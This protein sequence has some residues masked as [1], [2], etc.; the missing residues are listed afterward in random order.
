MF[1]LDN[2]QYK[3]ILKVDNLHIPAEKIT[4]ITGESGGGKTTLLR[5]LNHMISPT[6]GK[7]FYEGKDIMTADPIEH[8][9]KV[10]ML[11]QVPVIFPGSIERNL[12]IGRYFAAKEPLPLEELA[13]ILIR[14]KLFKELSRPAEELSGG[15]K[16]RLSL[17]RVLI[18]AAE[19]LLLDEPS[20]ALDEETEKLI[21][22][23]L[24]LYS[25]EN[26]KTLVMVTHAKE[27][28]VAHADF[29]V[30]ISEGEVKEGI[31]M[32]STYVEKSSV[33]CHNHK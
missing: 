5:L 12:N 17:A 21:M 1:Q 27:M 23:E 22:E 20:A 2:V 29:R 18:M 33:C 16:Q 9:R 13:E 7:V 28:A 4:C 19:T 26:K 8:R 3:N 30:A 15:E 32:S 10:V 11:P 24:V 31:E 14:V 6:A 25:R